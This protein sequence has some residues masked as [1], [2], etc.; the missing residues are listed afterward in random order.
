MTSSML[1]RECGPEVYDAA[2]G[3]LLHGAHGEGQVFHKLRGHEAALLALRWHGR[4]DVRLEDI[5][6]LA[7]PGPGEVQVQVR[8]CGICGTD[9]GEFRSG[10]IFIPTTPHPLTGRMAP[11]TLGHEVCGVVRQVGAGVD[12]PRP[13]QRVALDTVISCG[14]CYWCLRHQVN[15]CPQLAGLGLMFDGGLAEC[16]NVPADA[17]MVLPDAVSDTAGALLETLAVGVRGLRRGRL[18]LGERVCVL[19]GGAVGLLAGQA[20]RASGASEV[21]LVEPLPERRQIAVDVGM[22]WVEPLPPE[23]AQ[24]DL[25]LEC[26]GNPDAIAD[27]VRVCRTGGRVV[28]VGLY[29][30][31]VGF[32]FLSLVEHERELI[33]SMSHVYDDDFRAALALLGSGQVWVE[34]LVSDRVPL[35]RALD[36]GLLAL[37]REPERHLKI[38]ID[39][40]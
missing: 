2:R 15:R 14:G 17:A 38:L 37:A 3:H 9:V 28:L 16:C 7:P 23:E 10:P 30:R 1:K 40:A 32:E 24:A 31:A 12:G 39:A 19:G 27:A 33:G 20:A 22:D 6:P 21:G 4:G 8:C 13:G 35:H 36:D 29:Q 26:S 25:V 18:Q 5:E 34:P 11:L